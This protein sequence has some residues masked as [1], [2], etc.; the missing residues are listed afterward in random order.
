MRY[1]SNRDII[2]KARFNKEVS[3][4]NYEKFYEYFKDLYGKGLYVI[5]WHLNGEAEPFDNFFESAS[6]YSDESRD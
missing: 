5:G 2:I 1:G 6:E 4:M 3:C